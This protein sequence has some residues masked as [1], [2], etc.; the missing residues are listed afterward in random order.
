MENNQKEVPKRIYRYLDSSTRTLDLVVS[1]C[2]HY[3][4]P[5]DFNDPMDCRPSLEVDVDNNE[6]ERICWNIVQ[7][8]LLDEMRAASKVLNSVDSKK[9]D[10]IECSS[11]RRAGDIIKD[12]RYYA[13]NAEYDSD[14]YHRHLLAYRIEEELLR[15]HTKGIVCFSEKYDC[16]LMWSHY[17]N[18]HQGMCIGY[19]I[20]SSAK[21][22]VC[23]VEYGGDRLVLASD[24]SAMLDGNEI[25][26]REVNKA[27]LLRKAP[28]WSYE[29]EWRLVGS[30][31]MQSSP[32]ELE[33]VIFGLKCR[34]SSKFIAMKILENREGTVK[35]YEVREEAG[36][37][38]LKRCELTYDDE[39][40]IN[41]PTRNL[42]I[43]ELFQNISGDE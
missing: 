4:K 14:K 34:S 6:L 26:Q 15:Q 27:V 12:I 32:L 25:S 16:P 39:L 1:D 2:L 38:N 11:H 43:W 40:F 3:A 23:R 24:V 42:S 33:E 41:Y 10:H 36:K 13:T 17:G 19:S 9:T 22:N 5:S 18:H 30:S 28:S 21:N 35:F 20:P 29:K 7:N 8:R 37:F 31:G